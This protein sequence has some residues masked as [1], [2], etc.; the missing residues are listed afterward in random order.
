MMASDKKN[1]EIAK[2]L[3]D[4]S[5]DLNLQT[6]YGYSALHWASN[7]NNTDMAKILLESGID[8]EFK[9]QNGKS[10]L[11]VATTAEMREIFSR[12]TASRKTD[13]NPGAP[14]NLDQTRASPSSEVKTTGDSL[15][16]LDQ[17]LSGQ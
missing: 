2:A 13:L 11:G 14:T 10:A 12:H 6:E 7:K 1:L 4:A 5:T 17:Y 16:V 15:S 3:I 9:D 8:S